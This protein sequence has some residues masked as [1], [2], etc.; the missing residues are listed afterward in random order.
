MSKSKVSEALNI[1]EVFLTKDLKLGNEILRRILKSKGDFHLL[2]KYEKN[3]YK[4]EKKV[5]TLR[6]L[7]PPR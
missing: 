2:K 7:S 1:W 5:E 3:H 4:K 6:Y